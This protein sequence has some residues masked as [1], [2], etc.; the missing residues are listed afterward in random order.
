[1][2]ML[3]IGSSMSIRGFMRIGKKTVGFWYGSF[4]ID[5]LSARL[6]Q[7]WFFSVAHGLCTSRRIAFHL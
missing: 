2:D 7:Y 3:S 4:G 1:M 5:S 6:R